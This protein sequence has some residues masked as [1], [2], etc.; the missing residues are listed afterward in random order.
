MTRDIRT[1]LATAAL[2]ALVAAPSSAWAAAPWVERHLTLPASDWALDFGLGLGHVP[3]DSGAG[4]NAEMTVGLTSRIELGA[5]TG[6]VFGDAAERSIRADE[7]GCLFECQTFDDGNAVVASP[8]VRLRGA[9]VRDDVAEVALEGRVVLPHTGTDAGLLFGVPLEFHLGDYVRLDTGAYVPVILGHGTPF[10]VSLPVE[11][12]FQATRRF[13][14]GPMSGLV[15]TNPLRDGSA[16]D[17]S[18]G[19]GLGYQVTH[20]LDFKGMLLFPA[21]NQDSRVFGAGAGI[22]VR[23]E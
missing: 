13:W 4:I 6:L 3:F 8:Q 21:V 14:L 11:V 17:V 18:L 16:S 9:L 2:G 19:L 12:W 1:L 20:A 23:I 10:A 7:Y 5:R 15:F 22:Q